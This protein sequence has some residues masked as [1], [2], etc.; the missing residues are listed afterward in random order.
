MKNII[1][2]VF[3]CFPSAASAD[4][5]EI[6]SMAEIR[7]ELT[8][9]TLLIFDI[10]NTLVEPEGN[11]GSDQW[12]YYIEKAYKRDGL[13]EA[14]AEAKA[15]EAW[16]WA[17]ANVKVKAVEDT[18][19]ALVRE[20][21]KR[22]LK[23]IALTAR[24][25]KDAPATFRQLKDIGVDLGTDVVFVGDGPDKG[26]A[27]VKELKK[28]KLKPARIVF[29]DD[30][31]HHVKNVDAALTDARIPSVS[32]RYGAADSKVRAFN[33]VMSEAG[34]RTSAELLFQGRPPK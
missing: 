11:I 2:S 14:A 31:P 8:T 34:D 18:T 3:L 15:G 6:S 23:I 26:K 22:G 7:P 10:D 28:R 12:Y 33:E 16:S 20:Q 27:L 17:L 13:D 25:A 5:R 32:F 29:V 19:P 4:V 9:S 1:L 24:D 30:K 21:Q